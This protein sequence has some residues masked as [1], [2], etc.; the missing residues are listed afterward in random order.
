MAL[1][2][3]CVSLACDNFPTGGNRPASAFPTVAATDDA[4][5]S[6]FCTQEADN[7]DAEQRQLTNTGPNG[8]LPPLCRSLAH[9]AA[10]RP[11]QLRAHAPQTSL[12]R[13]RLPRPAGL[14]SEE[15]SER[16]A[17]FGRNVLPDAPEAA[18]TRLMQGFVSPM[19]ILVWAAIVIELAEAAAADGQGG[20]WADVSI[21][22][23]LQARI[24]G[25]GHQLVPDQRDFART[26]TRSARE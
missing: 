18:W 8:A 4:V 22:L 13:H 7:M 5:V 20:Y 6:P 11:D 23:I 26:P 12:R 24:R 14:T 19:E 21:L 9:P 16:L 3:A 25:C 10:H 15:S 17:K 2:S 1:F